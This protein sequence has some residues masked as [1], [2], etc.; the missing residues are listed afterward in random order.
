MTYWIP[1]QGH[2][3]LLACEHGVQD[4]VQDGFHFLVAC[5]VGV[6]EILSSGVL[7]DFH[8][9]MTVFHCG[10]VVDVGDV[11]FECIGFDE[12]IE[13]WDIRKRVFSRSPGLILGW[14]H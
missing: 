13:L 6:D 12:C 8:S 7:V 3:C 2:F 4:R 11:A 14:E 9:S 1:S 5:D 10:K